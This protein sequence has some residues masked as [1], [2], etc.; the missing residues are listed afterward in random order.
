M[1]E[2]PLQPIHEG[3]IFLIHKETGWTSFDVVSYFRSFLKR[4]YKLKKIKVGHAGTLD[5]LATG[6]L[7]VC[8]GRMT[9][10]INEFMNHPK[11][12]T[13]TICIGAT[14]P[15]CDKETE[16]DQ[17]FAVENITHKKVLETAEKMTGE[18]SQIP[19]IY[20]AIRVDGKKAYEYA[21]RNKNVI[22]EARKVSIEKFD[23]L[24]YRKEE[25]IEVDFEIKCSK[26]TYIR[27]IA[28][29]LGERLNNGG[30]LASL[31]RIEIGP[32]KL[33]NALT[34]KDLIQSLKE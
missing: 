23:I 6:L 7:I 33:E 17:Y 13:G 4:H 30:F 25:F 19:P 21:R 16:I 26:G 15:S 2:S 10:R 20:S 34:V 22:I 18:I 8:T 1:E 3:A 29:D 27:S 31:S 9:K 12:Y 24:D 14:R 5:P 28:R 11:T 32:Y